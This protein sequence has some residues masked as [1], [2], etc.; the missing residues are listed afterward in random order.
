MTYRRT[1]PGG[2]ISGPFP[3]RVSPGGPITTPF[4]EDEFMPVIPALPSPPVRGGDMVVPPR[5]SPPMRGQQAPF[6]GMGG[7]NRPFFGMGGQGRFG[8]GMRER[9]MNRG[10]NRPFFGGSRWR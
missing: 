9:M 6:L 5:P 4:P 8:G 3:G 2:P 7:Q 1:S 10:W